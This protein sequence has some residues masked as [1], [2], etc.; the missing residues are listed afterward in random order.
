MRNLMIAMLALLIAF[1]VAARADA[2]VP[3][4]ADRVPGDAILYLGWAGTDALSTQYD[5]SHL[6]KV[7]DASDMS[8][9]FSDFVPKLI[10]RVSKEDENVA[11][12]LTQVVQIGKPLWKHPT[13]FYFGGIDLNGPQPAPRLAMLCDA[14]DDAPALAERIGKLLEQAPQGQGP[15]PTV[16]TYGSLVVLAFGTPASI[17][18]D[19]A[20]PPAQ[21]VATAPKFVAGLAQVQHDPAYVE[22]VDLD[23]VVKLVDDIIGKMGDPKVAD[24]WQ[25]AR[26]ALGL[27]GIH[28]GISTGGFDGADWMTQAFVSSSEGTTGLQALF[29]ESPLSKEILNAV[30]QAADRMAVVKF[31]LDALVGNVRDIIAQIDP[32]TADQI[33]GG[34]AQ[35]NQMAG[36][37]LRKDFLAN[38]GD[39]WAFYSDREIAGPGVLGSVIVNRLKNA[40]AFDSA[41]NT[42]TQQAN[43]IIGQAM[44]QAEIKLE[45]H[46]QVVNGVTIHYFG[47]PF[48]TPSWA[49]KDGNLYLGLYPQVVS[50]AVEQV[51]GH[52]PS[53]LQKPEFIAVMKRLGDHDACSV[54]FSNLPVTAPEMYADLLLGTRMYLGYA[55]VFGV[56]PPAIV[57]PPLSKIVPELSPGGSVMW[58]DAAGLHEKS[59]CPFLGSELISQINVDQKQLGVGDISAVFTGINIGR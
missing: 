10:E 43:K 18:A 27:A 13:A 54:T 26:V 41:L 29:H 51:S 48:I 30:P 20:Q 58:T 19:F 53:I 6:K 35:I 12:V 25:H 31:D 28:N 1:S 36:V 24:R 47:I 11:E 15:L 23:A 59:I 21:S 8:A 50:G 34:L 49:V 52:G 57:V 17:D 38:L 39:E 45:F 33:D 44:Q 40:D 16:K 42:L 9:L 2:A 22:Y 55:D 46:E 32:S 14:G 4:L 5:A 37:D 7:V 56:H 3:P